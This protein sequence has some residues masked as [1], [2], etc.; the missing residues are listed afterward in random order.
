VPIKM[1]VMPI[2]SWAFTFTFLFSIFSFAHGF[3]R[4]HLQFASS[5]MNISDLDFF[6][7]VD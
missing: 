3:V 5:H 2:E 1:Y 7:K 4:C 6:I